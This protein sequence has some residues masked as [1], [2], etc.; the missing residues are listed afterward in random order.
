LL[1]ADGA[2]VSASIKAAAATE[3]VHSVESTKVVVST[4]VVACTITAFF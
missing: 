1:E 3:L 2:T 4:E